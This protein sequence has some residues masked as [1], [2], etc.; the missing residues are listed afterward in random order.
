[1][2]Q[3]GLNSTLIGLYLHWRIDTQNKIQCQTFFRQQNSVTTTNG[4][5]E[6]RLGFFYVVSNPRFKFSYLYHLYIL[7]SSF[8]EINIRWV[9]SKKTES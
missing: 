5:F 3:S 9:F 1:M 6:N 2:T 4:I 8:C 7:K